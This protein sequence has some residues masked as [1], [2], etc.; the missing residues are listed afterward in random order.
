MVSCS[1]NVQVT[2]AVEKQQLKIIIFE[3]IIINNEFNLDQRA[4]SSLH[5]GSLGIKLSIPFY[6][7]LF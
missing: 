3:F 2:Y 4:L 1:I 7:P 5:V 6:K